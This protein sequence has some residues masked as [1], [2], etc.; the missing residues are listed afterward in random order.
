MKKE[1]IDLKYESEKEVEENYSSLVDEFRRQKIVYISKTFKAKNIELVW[2]ALGQTIAKTFKIKRNLKENIE[3]GIK[4]KGVFTKY[5]L[6]EF[7]A[8]KYEISIFWLNAQDKYWLHYKITN[9][10][11]KNK[12]KIKF[13]EIVHRE[14]TFFGLADTAG[15]FLLKYSFRKNAKMFSNSI[16]SIIN[17]ATDGVQNEKDELKI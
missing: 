15:L 9:T 14:Q 5:L 7:N 8:E 13:K 3:F 17:N 6:E 11:F 10:M 12:F 1:K 16:K 2:E 4:V